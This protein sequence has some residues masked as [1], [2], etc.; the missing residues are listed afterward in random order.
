MRCHRDGK[1]DY[2]LRSDWVRYFCV[3]SLPELYFYCIDEFIET[4]RASLNNEYDR[5]KETLYTQIRN[6][7]KEATPKPKEYT[8]NKEILSCPDGVYEMYYVDDKLIRD[9]PRIG[10]ISSTLTGRWV[11]WVGANDTTYPLNGQVD[12]LD[13]VVLIREA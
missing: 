3:S 8:T 13:K 9:K 1:F 11:A 4:T 7:R 12:K 6:H 2:S 10:I 5:I